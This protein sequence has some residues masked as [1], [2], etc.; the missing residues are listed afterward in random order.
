MLSSLSKTHMI[1]RVKKFLPSLK[2]NDFITKGTA[3]IR[4]NLIDKDGN[5]VLNPLFLLS[6]NALHIL[7]YNSPGATG[8]FSIGFA[9]FYK[10]VEKGIIKKDKEMDT[11]YFKEKL[12]LDC[13]K[14][15]DII[16]FKI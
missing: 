3:G 4:A 12:I 8:S 5:F 7:N 13:I 10:L 9:L 16:L 6:D 15:V 1:N 14:E 11:H 2:P